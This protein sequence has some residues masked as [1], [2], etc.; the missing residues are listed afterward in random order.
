M[1]NHH[2]INYIEL[3]CR[4]IGA[5]KDFYGACFGWSFI[6]YGPD[7]I[8]VTQAGIDAGFFLAEKHTDTENGSALVVLFS[9]SLESTRDLII[10]NGGVIKQDIFSFPGGRRFHFA[11]PNQNELAVWSDKDEVG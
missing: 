6:D 8:A 11:D 5:T 9:E 3:P 4:D 7:Y 10:L 1:S 2:K